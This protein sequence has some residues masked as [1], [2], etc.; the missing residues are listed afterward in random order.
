MMTVILSLL[1]T[2]NPL[3]ACDKPVQYL[4]QGQNTPCTGYL[5]SPEKELEVRQMKETYNLHLEVKQLQK[6]RIDILETRIDNYQEYQVELEKELRNRED[7]SFW[8]NTLYFGLGVLLTGAIA[9]NV[10]R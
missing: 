8:K 6:E 5:F 1:L 9:T 2:L 4:S 3:Y 7:I 10:G